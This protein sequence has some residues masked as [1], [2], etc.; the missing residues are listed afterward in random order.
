M[1]ISYVLS[2]GGV[3]KGTWTKVRLPNEDGVESEVET[4]GFDELRKWVWRSRKRHL[5]HVD[6]KT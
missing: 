2:V 6:F 3:K 1:T 4:I 5:G